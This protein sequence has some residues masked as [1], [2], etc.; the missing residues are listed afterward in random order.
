MWDLLA[1]FLSATFILPLIQQPRWSTRTRA[2]VT[3]GWCVAIGLGAAYLTG[4]L[5][6]LADVRAAAGAV[7][8]VFVGA[9]TTYKGLAQP[10]GLAYTIET[11]SSPTPPPPDAHIP[12]HRPPG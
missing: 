2:L 8:L 10:T 4:R 9:I 7:L 6:N 1:G 12:R 3:F 11:A 5:D